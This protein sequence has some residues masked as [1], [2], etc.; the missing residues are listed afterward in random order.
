MPVSEEKVSI[1]L[2]H[3][4]ALSKRMYKDMEPILSAEGYHVVCPDL[5]GHGG[6]VHLGLFSF[7]ASTDYLRSQAKKTREDPPIE[8]IVIV[9]VSLGGQAALH[10][11]SQH[12]A[13]ADAAV[14]SGISIHPPCGDVA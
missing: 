3:G 7:P 5:P 9:G 10:F 11:L 2:V 8:K 13:L 14:V 1:I 12:P 4:G 6:S